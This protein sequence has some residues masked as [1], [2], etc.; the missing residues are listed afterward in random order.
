MEWHNDG[1]AA[2]FNAFKRIGT[3]N[4]SVQEWHI[5]T[6]Y[7]EKFVKTFF[8]NYFQTKILQLHY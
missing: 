6:L 7:R 8:K 3:S 5:F 1:V 4:C 2:L